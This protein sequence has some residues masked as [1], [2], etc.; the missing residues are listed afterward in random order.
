MKGVK[1]SAISDNSLAV[2]IDSQLQNRQVGTLTHDDFRGHGYK[3][4]VGEISA[5]IVLSTPHP[6]L[7]LRTFLDGDYDVAIRCDVREV[8]NELEVTIKRLLGGMVDKSGCVISLV[9]ACFT[10]GI[11]GILFHFGW[12]KGTRLAEAVFDSFA[13]ALES[14][15]ESND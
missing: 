6:S 8:D 11:G 1:I 15:L 2:E 5:D 10:L 7:L 12:K 14:T 9:L 13:V 3:N 4:K